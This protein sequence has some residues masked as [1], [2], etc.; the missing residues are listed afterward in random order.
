MSHELRTPLNSLLILAEQLSSNPQGNL[1][2]KQ[3]E[4]AETIRGSGVDLLKLINDILDLSKIESGT[5]TVDVGEVRF[6]EMRQN[7]ERTFRHVAEGKG[8]S[9]NIQI[10]Q[11]VPSAIYTDAQRLDQ[12]LKNLLS[13]AFK[14]TERGHVKLRVAPADSGWSADHDSLNRA[15]E[16]FAF[17]VSDSGIGIPLDKQSTIFD[18]FQQADGST[19]RR[20]GG[21]G[22]GLAISRE[23]AHLLGGEIKLE[24]HQGRGSTFTLFLP[25]A[26]SSASVEKIAEVPR[27][28]T[29]TTART[30][31]SER[32]VPPFTDVSISDDRFSILACEKAILIV[33]EDG[34]LAQWLLDSAHDAGF[35]AIVTP[36]G[37]TASALVREFAP[38]AIALDLELSDIEGYKVLERLKSDLATRHIPVIILSAAGASP[39]SAL[40]YGAI[41]ALEKPV[42]STAIRTVL[43]RVGAMT[44]AKAKKLLV[45]EDDATQRTS[46]RELIGN[47]SVDLREAA[48][49]AEALAALRDQEL[50]CVVL[51]LILPDMSGFKLIEQIRAEHQ[52]LPIIVYTGKVLSRR[53][54]EQLNRIAQTVI[55]KDVR[56]PER[57][58]DQTALWLH[59]DVSK[60]SKE[61][62][63][64]LQR[65][66]DPD[67]IFAGKKVLIVDDDIRNI[68]AM[69]SLLERYKMNVISA[70]AGKAGIEALQSAR[71]IDLVLMDI[72]LPEMDGY[73]TIR[74]IRTIYGFEQLPI[75]ALT[76]K[77]MKGDREKCIDA[78]ASDYI[79]KP[80]E[81]EELLA[82]LRNWLYR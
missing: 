78:G 20:Y 26:Y 48:T 21:T 55:V 17:S 56:S 27:A 29:A 11:N 7:L 49:A 42:D 63:D 28:E 73:D 23:L 69:T 53:E 35:K 18:A 79:A 40:K 81:T 38:I 31:K 30:D 46:I 16:V 45:V 2:P 60:L 67:E 62:R 32:P 34:D 75:I 51:D 50:G 24:S 66:H 39:Q 70:E 9:F 8:V 65:L 44:G 74:A 33:E 64:L 1:T 5:V 22:L 68:F 10:D 82:L 61:R 12:V 4:F 52:Q 71:D 6:D 76:A 43:A 72:M 47:G 58:F 57:L 13:N 15:K 80:V 3:V 19:N 59:R 41:A 14:F 37:R 25:E 36:Q 54:E 77:A